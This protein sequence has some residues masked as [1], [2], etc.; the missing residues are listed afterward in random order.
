MS[1]VL[2]NAATARKT[3]SALAH[4]LR[5]WRS[6]RARELAWFTLAGVLFGVIDLGSLLESD[7]GKQLLPVTL[8]LMLMPV[9]ECMVLL[10][11]W[12]PADRSAIDHPH[13]VARLMG[14]ALLA[15][16][17]STL[18]L[19]PLAQLLPW[20]TVSDLMRAKK[21]L[22]PVNEMSAMAIAGNT[23]GDFMPLAM[24]L[25]VIELLGRRRRSEESVQRMLHEHSQLRRRAMGSRLAALQAQVEP[26]LLFDALVDIEQAYARADERAPARMEQLI[27]HLRV[28][29]PRLR[30]TGS[31]LDAEAELLETY[32][33]VL[34]GLGHAPLAFETRWP[35]ELRGA[36]VP[37]MILLPL[38]QRALRMAI[39]PPTL[40]TLHADAPG[41]RLRVV[42]S[43][44]RPELCGDDAELQALSE[45]LR[46]LTGNPA[47]LRCDSAP[48]LTQFT[49][50]LG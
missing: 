42:L 21:H 39:V 36:S 30:E 28:A 20:P 18:V 23:L 14:V 16:A 26:Q 6:L 48:G 1:V 45:R 10:A 40:C 17:I 27:R 11:L 32:L 3:G 35:D 43:F 33:A 31:R 22:P 15:A 9:L 25:A 38:L 7:V 19:T 29:L 44:D 49:L 41:G 24:M 13:R 5:A 47:R 46:V 50:E 8:R 4:V 37:P 12:L 34:Q 2:S